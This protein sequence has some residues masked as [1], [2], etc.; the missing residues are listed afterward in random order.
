MQ[1][2]LFGRRAGGGALGDGGQALVLGHVDGVGGPD[3]VEGVVRLFGQMLRFSPL[4]REEAIKQR[5]L[6]S[7]ATNSTILPFELMKR[8]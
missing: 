3:D 6:G 7:G 1:V 5:P 8:K 4:K 2:V